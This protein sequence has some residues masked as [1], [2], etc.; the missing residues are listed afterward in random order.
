MNL[1][2]VRSFVAIA[3]EG[4]FQL[5]AAEEAGVVFHREHQANVVIAPI[6]VEPVLA[7]LVQRDHLAAF[8]SF[9]SRTAI[10]LQRGDG[11]VALRTEYGVSDSLNSSAICIR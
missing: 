6:R 7:A 4:Q 1:E 9:F 8:G 5:A 3:D 11:A 10:L 2:A